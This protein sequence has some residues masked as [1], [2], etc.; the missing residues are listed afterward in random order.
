MHHSLVEYYEE[1]VL[2]Q[3]HSNAVVSICS[4]LYIYLVKTRVFSLNPEASK[5]QQTQP[6]IIQSQN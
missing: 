6:F 1:L 3:I 4:L 2:D 5:S